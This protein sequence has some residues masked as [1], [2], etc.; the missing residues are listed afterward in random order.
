MCGKEEGGCGSRLVQKRIADWNRGVNMEIVSSQIQ[1]TFWREFGRVLM[2][3][4]IEGIKRVTVT[5]SGNRDT[6]E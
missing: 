4:H 5:V 3:D 1:N 6:G 2:M